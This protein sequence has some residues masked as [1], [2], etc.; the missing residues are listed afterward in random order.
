[1]KRFL[2]NLLFILLGI[3]IIYLI[4]YPIRGIIIAFDYI[5][6]KLDDFVTWFMET[7]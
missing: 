2:A 6:D 1:M 5:T 7:L 4:L 3:P